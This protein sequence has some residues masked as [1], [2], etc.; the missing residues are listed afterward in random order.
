MDR[1]SSIK[2]PSD[3]ILQRYNTC[4]TVTLKATNAQVQ[5]LR[6]MTLRLAAKEVR[7]KRSKASTYGTSYE[8]EKHRLVQTVQWVLTCQQI[9]QGAA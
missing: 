5:H 1:C 2:Q 6:L 4:T 9:Q 3:M 8:I 7:H